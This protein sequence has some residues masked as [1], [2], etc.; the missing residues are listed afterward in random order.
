MVEVMEGMTTT[1]ATTITALGMAC[2][3]SEAETE[4]EEVWEAIVMVT[5]ALDST[6]AISST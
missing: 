4:V 1:M 6:V 2:L 3:K 5:V